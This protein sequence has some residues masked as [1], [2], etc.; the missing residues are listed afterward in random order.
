[1]SFP[2]EARK[3]K[4]FKIG[5]KF[6][7]GRPRKL[8]SKLK[9]TGY[10]NCEICDAFQVI[11][12]LNFEQLKTVFHNPDATVLEKQISSAIK[13]D[14]ERGRLDSLEIILDR[15]YGKPK[16][17]TEISGEGGGPVEIIFK[18][19]GIDAKT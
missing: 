8:L 12:S 6:S 9:D 18:T 13:H 2:P 5:N 11:L 10:R 19:I 14:I 3:K 15:I 16:Q 1:M 7:K 17:Q 4:A